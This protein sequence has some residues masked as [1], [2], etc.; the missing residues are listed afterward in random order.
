MKMGGFNSFS[1]RDYLVRHANQHVGG[2]LQNSHLVSINNSNSSV[3][4][5]SKERYNVD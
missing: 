4:H 3:I 5:Y 1:S 2:I